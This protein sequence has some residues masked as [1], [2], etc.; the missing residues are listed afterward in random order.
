MDR[1][2]YT[3]SV[4]VNEAQDF[5]INTLTRR[6]DDDGEVYFMT[7]F[8]CVCIWS[9]KYLKTDSELQSIDNRYKLT[10]GVDRN[11]I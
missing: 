11:G 3:I 10:K 4:E 1:N 2:D 9:R 6:I 5:P 8:G 7:T